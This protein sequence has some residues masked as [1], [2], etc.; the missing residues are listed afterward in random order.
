[1]NK[2]NLEYEVERLAKLSGKENWCP[3]GG[4]Q[5]P[6]DFGNNVIARTYTEAQVRLHPWRKE[7]LVSN[8]DKVYKDRYADISVLDLGSGEGAMSLALWDRGVRD[9]TC[10]EARSDNV[11]KAKFVLNHFGAEANIVNLPIGKFLDENTKKYDVVIFMGILYH[12]LNPFDIIK[13]ISNITNDKIIVETV[14]AKIDNIEFGNRDNYSA[15]KDGFF[16]RVDTTESSTAGLSDLE[17]WP[18]MGALNM[19]MNE[20]SFSDVKLFEFNEEAPFDYLDKER[21]IGI[22]DKIDN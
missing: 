15:N 2:E 7:M 12:L 11:E 17:L 20:N 14:V 3:N 13:K 4:W 10:V 19:L 21:I 5:Y 9:I 16:V 8:L 22:C 6:F 18:T 1:M